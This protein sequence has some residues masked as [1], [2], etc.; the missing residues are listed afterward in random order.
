MSTLTLNRQSAT[1]DAQ[2]LQELADEP[3]I[4]DGAI[5][6]RRPVDL[7]ELPPIQAGTVEQVKDAIERARVAQAGWQA[8]GFKQRAAILKRAGKRML[9]ARAEVL[10]IMRDEAGK[11][12]PEALMSE[13]IGPLD[14]VKG[15]IKVV[16]PALKNRKVPIS[17]LAWPGKSAVVERRPRGVVGI[18]TPWNY[19]LGV[20]FK[21][22]IPAL[23]TGNAVVLKPSENT[24]GTGAW[25]VKMMHAELPDPNVLQL[26]QGDGEVGRAMLDVEPGID[27]CV[28]TGSVATGRKVSARCGE[29]L[30]PV[31][32]ELGGK[33][34]A[35]VLRDCNLDRTIAGVLHWSLHNVGQNCGAIERVYVEDAIA[36]DFVN[37]LTAACE[38]LRTAPAAGD[39]DEACV[40]VCPLNNARQLAI[41]ER[42]VQDAIAKGAVVRCGGKPTGVG[43]WY[44]AT[45]ID[46]C[47]QEMAVI[48]EETF[49]PVIPIVRV[50]DAEEALRLANDSNYGLNGSVWTTD[51]ARGLA[52]ARRMEVGTA[53]VNNHAFTGA[54]PA[55]PWTGVKGSGYGVANSEHALA[56]FLRPM[57]IVKDKAGKPDP[58][59][60]PVDPEML[61]MGDAL[62]EAQLGN[63]PKALPL[64]GLISKRVKHI[65]AHVRGQ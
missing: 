59:W 65:L 29:K 38:K 5:V 55:A 50:P 62:A 28:F 27:S 58:F 6:R 45:V 9:K 4:R 37:K 44:P 47:T 23:L 31:S 3:A 25:F 51:I 24:P 34:A 53:F 40:D 2:R 46:N 16:K 60:L 57:T 21:P 64:P 41:V 20:F 7:T 10:E 39:V 15:W 54:L 19:P 63:I 17:P 1:L 52:L 42:H 33:D 56:T 30:I 36:D 18:I 13:V 22:V 8:L 61:A 43:L 48:A 12:G 14:Y 49:G 11:L 26:L 35:I 32:C